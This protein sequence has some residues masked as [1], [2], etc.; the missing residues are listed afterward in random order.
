MFS[1]S[2]SSGTGLGGLE[3]LAAKAGVGTGGVTGTTHGASA[4]RFGAL[5]TGC[6]VA[7][8]AGAARRAARGG[9]LLRAAPVAAFAG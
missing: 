4:D 6:G 9:P 1:A 2:G 7:G 3:A 5:R 8:N